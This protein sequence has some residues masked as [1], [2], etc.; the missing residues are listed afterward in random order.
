MACRA[1]RKLD[2]LVGME[3]QV[4]CMNPVA[5]GIA[6]PRD[7]SFVVVEDL[8]Y[9][10]TDDG[11]YT[12]YLLVKRGLDTLVA[13]RLLERALSIGRGVAVVAGFKDAAATAVQYVAVPGDKGKQLIRVRSRKGFII[14]KRLCKVKEKPHPSRIRGNRF[15]IVLRIR[16]GVSTNDI[17]NNLTVLG[18]AL[19]PAYYGYQRFGTIRPITHVLGATALYD[20]IEGYLMAI[21]DQPFPRESA[22]AIEYRL[23]RK[24][25]PRDYEEEVAIALKRSVGDAVSTVRRTLKGLDYEA[26]QA[27]AFNLY[28]SERIR[29]SIPL[30]KP[31]PGERIGREGLPIAIVPG[32]GYIPGKESRRIYREAL[33]RIGVNLDDL[34]RIPA[35]GFWRPVA[36]RV[37]ELRWVVDSEGRLLTLSFRLAKGMY[38]TVVLRELAETPY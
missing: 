17:A 20:D 21:L 38:A 1:K 31:V 24:G 7:R 30:S 5:V 28:V 8:A 33:A 25:V 10:C 34:A 4:L 37:E 12:L 29:L 26:L 9:T 2:L 27:L 23:K 14:A 3:Y 15:T 36:F 35:K 11:R 13:L 6:E 32:K 18:G 16:K 22:E 19:L